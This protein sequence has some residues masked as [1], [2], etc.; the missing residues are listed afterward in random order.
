MMGKGR[1][2]H[3]GTSWRIANVDFTCPRLGLLED[4]RKRIWRKNYVICY[5]VGSGA[6]QPFRFGS[7][8][9]GCANRN[10]SLCL[11]VPKI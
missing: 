7:A 2:K 1:G 4:L 5:E 6:P 8:S 3:L 11:H 10:P 9:P